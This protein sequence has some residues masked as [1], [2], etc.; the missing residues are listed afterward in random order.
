MAAD[1]TTAMSDELGLRLED[2][3]ENNYIQ[4]TK[5]KFL[6][7]AQRQVASYLHDAYLTELEYVDTSCV[8]TA[9][10]YTS[11]PLTSL[12][13]GN[14]VLRGGKGIKRVKV[15]VSGD[16]TGLWA[17]EI[18]A[19]D[20]KDRE[21]QFL[22]SSDT[23]PMYYIF[24]NKINLLVDTYAVNTTIDVYYQKLPPELS[25]SV[26]PVLNVGFQDLIIT[27]AEATLWRADDKPERREAA[28]QLVMQEIEILNRRYRRP[29][30]IG[31]RG[32]EVRS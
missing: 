21:N 22:A 5:I 12:N 2:A 11:Y 23:A 31:T 30:G 7:A 19:D 29:E 1:I 20:L 26:D 8:L 15:H 6:S 16:S 13:S 24:N 32:R 3:D 4:A 17:N 28:Y 27:L 18:D 25:T 14:G 10:T 9:S